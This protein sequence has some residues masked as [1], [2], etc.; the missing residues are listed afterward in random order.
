MYP[1]NVKFQ[2]NAVVPVT[3]KIELEIYKKVSIL[4]FIILA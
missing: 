3:K 2:S 4:T 1:C